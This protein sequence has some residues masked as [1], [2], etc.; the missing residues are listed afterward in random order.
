MQA[1][2][3]VIKITKPRDLSANLITSLYSGMFA[4]LTSLI[5]LYA[6]SQSVA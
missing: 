5:E 4:D 6:S 3:S 1:Y 2:L